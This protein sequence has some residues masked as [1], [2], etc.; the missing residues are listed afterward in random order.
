MKDVVKAREASGLAAV[1][2]DVGGKMEAAKGRAVAAGLQMEAVKVEAV[3]RAAGAA[4]DLEADV[5]RV[6]AGV[7]REEAAGAVGAAEGMGCNDR[8]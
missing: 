1:G 3:A 7:A 4:A 5:D 2:L 6:A 8:M